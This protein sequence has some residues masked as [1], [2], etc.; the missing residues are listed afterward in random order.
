MVEESLCILGRTAKWCS[1]CGKVVDVLQKITSWTNDPKILILDIY[2]FKKI[3]R[4]EREREIFHVLFHSPNGCHDQSWARLKPG[5]MSFFQMSQWVQRPRDL[6]YLLLLSKYI[7]GELDPKQN[8]WNLNW[9]PS[10]IRYCRWQL[11]L[12][13]QSILG[14]ILE[15]TEHRVSGRDFHCSIFHNS[16]EVGATYI[17]AHTHTHI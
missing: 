17:Y 11:Y 14:C 10:G 15:R 6:D 9:H 1:W 13:C 3:I 4:H 12:Q 8:N 2:I 5:T 16:Q 7:N